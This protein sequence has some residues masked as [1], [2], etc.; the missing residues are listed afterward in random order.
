MAVVRE[1]SVIFAALIG[2]LFLNERV[3]SKRLILIVMIAFGA[4]VTKIGG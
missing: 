3:G 1:T 4:V 2:S